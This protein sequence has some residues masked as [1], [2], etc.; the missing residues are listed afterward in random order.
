MRTAPCV[1]ALI[2]GAV[3][4]PFASRASSS[5]PEQVGS[6]S[7]NA[8]RSSFTVATTRTGVGRSA[9]TTRAASARPLIRAITYPGS[10][11]CPP[12]NDLPRRVAVMRSVAS[13][14]GAPFF[15]SSAC[16][17]DDSR[18][19]SRPWP[20]RPWVARGTLLSRHPPPHRR[21]RCPLP[22]DHS[23]MACSAPLI[24]PS[25]A[26]GTRCPMDGHAE[27]PSGGARPPDPGSTSSSEM[28]KD[29]FWVCEQGK[30]SEHSMTCDTTRGT[31]LGTRV[32]SSYDRG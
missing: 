27:H 25:V 1:R 4:N 2:N 19:A 8:S 24:L 10:A 18:T 13:Y 21:K 17:P 12:C 11:D 32:L 9:D 16:A 22:L 20:C 30:S 14:L 31:R 29:A 6:N 28:R 3:E 7:L 23:W 5:K 26:V 15:W